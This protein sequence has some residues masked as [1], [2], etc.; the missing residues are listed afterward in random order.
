MSAESASSTGL[1]LEMP[2][3][4]ADISG[5]VVMAKRLVEVGLRATLSDLPKLLSSVGAPPVAR[6]A[7]VSVDLAGSMDRPRGQGQIEVRG[8]GGGRTGLP[9]VDDLQAGFSLRDGTVSIAS[10]RA[11]VANGVIA[12]EGSARLFGSSLVRMLSAPTLD[13]HLDG[14]QI[15]L[16]QLIAGGMVAGRV[17]FSRREWHHAQA[18]DCLACAPGHHGRGVRTALAA[19][20]YRGR[21]RP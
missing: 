18:Q 1:R 12:G 7:T 5:K 20:R 10:L 6:S 19:A 3:A 14:E 17:S 11:G 8:M 2:G 4:S 9:A 21:G 15:A 13:F 16:E